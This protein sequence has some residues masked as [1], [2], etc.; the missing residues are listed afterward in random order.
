MSF[1]KEFEH[2]QALFGAA[3]QEFAV[4]G[5][6]SASINSILENAGMSK[7][8]FYYHF[9]NKEGLYFALVES[10]IRQKREFLAG[11]MQPVDFQQG[12][13]Q[14]LRTQIQYG[15]AFAQAH[16]NI[17]RFGESFLREKGNPIYAKV[18]AQY[19]FD[20]DALLNG[21]IARAYH[22]G[23]LR[24][25]LPLPFIQKVIGYLFTHAAEIAGLDHVEGAEEN[26]A[27]LLTF[28]ESGL[29]KDRE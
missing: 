13:F 2:S 1:L 3:I 4:N 28:M 6:E 8:Q 16:P 20:N 22:N 25:D 11:I 26:L 19:N 27:H 10:L 17:N 9:T 24:P 5:Y 23:E 7:G 18:L 15:V 14:I 29:R 12:L 21:L